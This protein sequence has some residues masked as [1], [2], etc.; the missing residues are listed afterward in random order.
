MDSIKV[1]GG[2][3]LNGVIPISGAKNAALPL[4]IASLLTDETLTLSNV[5]RLRDVAQ[6]MQILSNHGVD[7][8]VNGKRSGQDDLAGQTL[9]L[10]AREIVDTTAPYELVSKMRASFWVIGPLVARSHEA[11]VSLPGGCAIG[12]RPVDFFIDGLA[13]LGAEIEIDGGYVIVKAPGGLKGARVEFPKVSVGATHTIMMAAT[14][15]SGETEIVNA[16]REPEVVDL[17]KCLKAMGAKIEGEGTSTIRIQGVPRL[18]GAHHAVVPDRIETGTYAMA[19]AMTGG[20]VLLQ[21]ARSDLLETALETL[22]Q[23]GADITQTADGIKVYRNGNGIQPVDITTEPFPGF[24][25]DL[26]A[27]FMALMTKAGGTSRITETIFENRFMHV[28]ELARLGAQIHVDGRTAM[29][30][31]V[32]TLRGAPVMATDLRASVSLVIAGLAAEGETT[33]SRVYHLD[34]GFERLEDK[35]TRCGAKIERISA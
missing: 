20:D 28:Q 13:A 11:R 35:L 22:R 26:Q 17:A 9:N 6:L 8:S 33:V 7:Y 3:E 31:G 25:T 2:A 32:S 16:A 10:T 12:T 5:P 1:V 19:V 15:A 27:Q 30:D 18:H 29:I 21:G 23:T 34:R 14:L 24:P 4:M